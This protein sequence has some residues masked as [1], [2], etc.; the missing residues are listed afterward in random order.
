MPS[1]LGLAVRSH[2]M[3]ID[4]KLVRDVRAQCVGDN[5]AATLGPQNG[6]PR[7]LSYFRCGHGNRRKASEADSCLDKAKNKKQQ[8]ETKQTPQKPKIP[9]STHRKTKPFQSFLMGS[10]IK[11]LTTFIPDLLC[12]KF[13]IRFPGDSEAPECMITT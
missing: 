11:Y 7:E 5:R 9:Q 4:L 6:T 10:C 13:L 1:V 3:P 12:M 8:N 2:A